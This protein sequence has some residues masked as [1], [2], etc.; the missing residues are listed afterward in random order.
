MNHIVNKIFSP[1]PFIK[2]FA[3][4]YSRSL[5]YSSG[6][7]NFC[8]YKQKSDNPALMVFTF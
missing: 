2:E 4:H 8:C 1:W 7:Q 6:K 5:G 3:A